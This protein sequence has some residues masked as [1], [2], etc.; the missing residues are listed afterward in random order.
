MPRASAAAVLLLLPLVLPATGA[1]QAPAPASPPVITEPGESGHLHVDDSDPGTVWARGDGW[2]ASFAAGG[3][4]FVPFL[5]SD[6]PRNFPLGM[7]L[8]AATVGATSLPLALHH[9]PIRS[10]TRIA[11]PR[12]SLTEVYELAPGQVE[13]LFVFERPVRGG[14]LSVRMLVDTELACSPGANGGLRF[15]NERGGVDYGRAIAIDAAGASCEVA[16]RWEP[17][18]LTLTV[19]A[20]FAA[21][22]TFPLTI[23]PLVSI[24]GVNSTVSRSRSR[25]DC[26]YVGSHAGLWAA[27][28]EEAYS[29]TDHDIYLRPYRQDGTLEPGLYI[30]FT[31]EYWSAPQI[32]SHRSASQFLVVATRGLAPA[33]TMIWGR[34]VGYQDN[35][36][37]TVLSPGS[38]FLIQGWSING[39]NA[40]VGGDPNADAALPGHYCVTWERNGQIQYRL[41]GT[42]GTLQTEQQIAPGPEFLS[43]LRVSKS[44]GV[45]PLAGREWILVWQKRYSPTDE[46]ILG[47]IVAVDGSLRVFQ[48]VVDTSSAVETNPEVSSKTDPGNGAQRFLVTYERLYPATPSQAARTGLRANLFDG[49][50]SLTGHFDLS[51]VLTAS[52]LQ[53]Q[54]QP[55]VET[56]GVRF[57]I[58]YSQWSALTGSQT[59]PYL[60]TAHLV[61]DTLT[62]TSAPELCNGYAG[63]DD[64]LQIASARDSAARSHRYFATWTTTLLSNAGQQCT[65]SFYDG[66]LNL[67]PAAYYENTLP[68]CGSPT[69]TATGVPAIGNTI[70]LQL[71]GAVGLPFLLLGLPASPTTVCAGCS[72]GLQQSSMTSL[73]T[74]S[75]AITVPPWAS[76][77]GVRFGAQGFDALAPGGCT[78]AVPFRLGNQLTITLL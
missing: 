47:S 54:V 19:P 69:L 65:G 34:L 33:A 27:V 56:D 41:V 74:T 49:G 30:D 64:D 42:D 40:D 5:G 25:P 26:A 77:I 35:A 57:A 66:H 52:G 23:D 21:D 67:L 17:G 53:N 2:K 44:C 3:F 13:Q 29:Q 31:T 73:F 58:G 51:A 8:T 60:A 55:G 20:A 43:N 14:E 63:P 36:G 4:T 6:A 68:G 39:F 28:M 7:R 61:N 70:V 76:L 22:A 16:S 78:T 59:A 11:L 62:L 48:F 18:Q 38:Q 12:G 45:G 10:G 46:D 72:L 9:A 1:G 50:N 24:F 75:H 71:S 15:A 37:V 32:A